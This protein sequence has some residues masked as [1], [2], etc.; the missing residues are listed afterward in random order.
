MLP[1]NGLLVALLVTNSRTRH[2]NHDAT[3]QYGACEWRAHV[4]TPPSAVNQTG[5]RRGDDVTAATVAPHNRKG[6]TMTT[7]DKVKWQKIDTTKLPDSAKKLHSALTAANQAAA[8]ARK[9]F[10]ADFLKGV[11]VPA[12]K[13]IAISYRFGIATALVDADAAP[14]GGKGSAPLADWLAAQA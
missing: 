4:R 2:C 11:T 7:T 9:A 3:G 12:G 6:Y 8:N 10:E 14:S 1:F 13:K 5:V